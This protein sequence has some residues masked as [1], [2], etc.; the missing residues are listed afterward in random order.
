MYLFFDTETNGLPKNYEAPPWDWWPDIVQLARALVTKDGDIISE[1]SHI[2]FIW[3]DIPQEQIDIHWITSEMSQQGRSTEFTLD[4]FNRDIIKADK[5]IAHNINF[6]KNVIISSMIKHDRFNKLIETLPTLCTMLTTIN[7]CK[8]QTEYG[9]KRPKLEELY[10][11]LFDEE[12]EGAHNALVDVR[13]TVRC[14]FELKRLQWL[15]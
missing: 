11:H 12:I 14:A 8:I 13:A 5:L 1:Q 10:K 15:K 2:L 6:D 9:Y 4:A 7:V 3:E